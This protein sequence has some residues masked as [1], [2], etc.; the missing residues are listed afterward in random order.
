MKTVCHD[1]PGFSGYLP[2]RER[3]PL[4]VSSRLNDP[5]VRE[6]VVDKPLTRNSYY[7]EAVIPDEQ[8]ALNICVISEYL[9]QRHE[10]SQLMKIS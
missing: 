8:H 10:L 6:G 1:Q 9:Q 5:E 4:S 2:E 7:M 3:S